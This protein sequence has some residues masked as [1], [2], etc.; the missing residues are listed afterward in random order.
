MAELIDEIDFSIDIQNMPIPDPD[1]ADEPIQE[2]D[3]S[4]SIGINNDQIQEVQNAQ[5]FEESKLGLFLLGRDKVLGA[6]PRAFGISKP[7]QKQSQK[8]IQDFRK[9]NKFNKLSPKEQFAFAEKDILSFIKEQVVRGANVATLISP[10]GI[11][12][13]AAIVGELKQ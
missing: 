5:A 11:A 2:M 12:K 7:F 9:E 3:F 1:P 4:Q 13:A 10:A 6:I 8:M